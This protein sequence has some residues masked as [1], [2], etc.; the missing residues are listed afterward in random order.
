VNLRLTPAL[1]LA[2]LGLIPG[3][4]ARGEPPMARKQTRTDLLGDPLPESVIAR[5][6][7]ERLWLP[8]A[9]NFVFSSDGKLLAGA[10]F[11]E[12]RLWEVGT[13]KERWRG[14]F[15]PRPLSGP[16]PEKTHLC[17]SPDG[18]LLALGSSD[19]TVHIWDIASGRETGRLECGGYVR[20]LA[21]S[22]DA[23]VLAVS[24]EKPG[25]QLWEPAAGK[26]LDTWA[27]S[28]FVRWLAFSRDGRTLTSLVGDPKDASEGA[29]IS[30]WDTVSGEE[31]RRGRLEW[32]ATWAGALSP[33]GALIAL[34]TEDGK[35]IR[36]LDAKSGK[37]A[38]RT[39]GEAARP[40]L[41]AFASDGRTLTAGT[42][43]GTVRVWES[44]TGKLLHRITGLASTV[45]RVALSP[46]GSLLVAAE[47]GYQGIHLLDVATGNEV[48]TF[49]GHRT[50]GLIVAFSR[51]GKAVMT[52][53]RDF[54]WTLPPPPDC[55]VWSLRR[56]DPETGKEL[57]VTARNL[58]A[59]VCA[60]GFSADGS[61]LATLHQDGALRLWDTEAFRELRDW[62]VPTSERRLLRPEVSALALSHD[63]K[64]LFGARPV[65]IARW[66]T[67][68]GKE[69][70][71]LGAFTG[72]WRVGCV[73]PSPD[74]RLVAATIPSSHSLTVLLDAS[75]GQKLYELPSKEAGIVRAFSA[76][77]RTLVVASADEV[78]LWE[79]ASGRPRGRLP[80]A[81][82]IFAAAFSPDGRILA[83]G[84]NADPRL[85]LW[86]LTS[87]RPEPP[88][89]PWDLTFS[90]PPREPV[91]R[92]ECVSSLAF[93]PD[94]KRLAMAG[95]QNTALVFD[96]AALFKQRPAR[97]LKLSA[98]GREPL[99]EDLTGADGDRAFRAIHRVAASGPEGV[100][101]IEARLNVLPEIAKELPRLIKDLD[102]DAFETR[103]QASKELER[104]GLQAEA[105]L[106][107]GLK[108]DPSAEVRKRLEQLLERLKPGGASPASPELI[109][110]RAVEA[111]E[112]NGGP[113]ARAVLERLAKSQRDDRLTADA[114]ASLTRLAKRPARP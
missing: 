32:P 37:E 65:A 17:F 51:D 93:S 47:K 8:D 41:I 95:S 67:A 40:G 114:K 45:D 18:K 46:D 24:T 34:P 57:R 35:T 1:L 87:D 69:L 6:G 53:N 74:G 28:Y 88:L 3:G 71:P 99:W 104:L 48:H 76:D 113:E 101:I 78:T 91:G 23:K 58:K 25:I 56:W 2:V 70:L 79:V 21:F 77:G 54:S 83:L 36:L 20:Q 90:R 59:Q 96:V 75:T 60:A 13:G 30:T 107:E 103:E 106:Q 89:L 112:M 7:T 82:A 110:L 31:H 62:K 92:W 44:A 68:T 9:D 49:A 26:Q 12:L 52:A 5:L 105:A 55:G 98:D 27:Q 81:G 84:A 102:D 94:G 19:P 42:R 86:D 73:V 16:Q 63:G 29:I 80:K 108:K 33:D 22:R 109:G 100:A 14:H 10:S 72:Q 61:R 15:P 85:R 11:G 97:V 111:L 4:A 38:C 50:G 64:T 39:K 66:E 43:D